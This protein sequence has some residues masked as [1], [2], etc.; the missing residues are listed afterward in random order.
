MKFNPLLT[1]YCISWPGGLLQSALG[2]SRKC[3]FRGEAD[4]IKASEG[5]EFLLG[6]PA[7][8]D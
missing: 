3:G 6:E 4:H 7:Q 5:D 2:A 1:L 8:P